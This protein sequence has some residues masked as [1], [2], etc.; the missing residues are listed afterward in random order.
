MRSIF[1]SMVCFASV[2]FADST[3]PLFVIERSTNS[4][5]VHYEAQLGEDRKLNESDPVVVYW[6]M[7]TKAGKRQE[8]SGVEKRRAYGFKFEPDAATPGSV[9]LHLVPYDKRKLRVSA[10]D[11]AA[12][13][14]ITIDGKPSKL[15]KIF[16]HT[17]GHSL[18]PGVDY[19][20]LFGSEVASGTSTYEKILNPSKKD[21]K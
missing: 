16:I 9:L 11:G 7:K 17:V 5:V 20:E 19:I 2:A 15:K 14:E 13:A 6:E 4:N 12:S 1:L 18:I 10:V 3:Q 8:L 21:S